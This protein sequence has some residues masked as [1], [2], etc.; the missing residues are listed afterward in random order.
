MKTLKK[1]SKR[2]VYKKKLF[3]EA[4]KKV[5]FLMTVP[6]RGGR[7]GGKALE[8]K[9]KKKTFWDVFFIC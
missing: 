2:F 1:L 3:K 8:V 4:A 5:I 6:L 7:E 9:K